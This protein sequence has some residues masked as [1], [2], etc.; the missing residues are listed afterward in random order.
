MKFTEDTKFYVTATG[1][2]DAELAPTTG[3]PLR[4]ENKGNNFVLFNV[5]GNMGED[6]LFT[7][8]INIPSASG[9]TD[10]QTAVEVPFNDALAS[11]SA[12]NVQ[13]ALDKLADQINDDGW[14]V[15]NW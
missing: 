10:D 6:T 3:T 8:S 11:L 2:Q 5:M 12:A 1:F 14:S 7:E 13:E 9:G 15:S 4:V